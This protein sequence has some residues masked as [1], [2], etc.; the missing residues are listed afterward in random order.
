MKHERIRILHMLPVLGV[1]GAECMAVELAT[2]LSAG[3]FASAVVSLFDGIGSR[4][5][6]VLAAHDIPF[7][8]LGKRPGFDPGLLKRVVH[9]VEVFAPHVVHTHL[10]TLSYATPALLS[11]RGIAAV[12]TMHRTTDR[13]GGRITQWLHGHM[14]RRRVVPVAV[15]QAI[16]DS[17]IRNYRLSDVRVIPNGIPVDSYRA[18][19]FSRDTW[20]TREGFTLHEVL[21]TC[22]AR[23]RPVKNHSLLLRA[24]AASA[25]LRDRAKL[26][27]VGAGELEADLRREAGE[28]EI[29]SLVRFMGE[30]TDVAD[31]LHASDAFVLSSDSEA[32]SLAVME[33]MA[34]GLPVVCTRVGGNPELVVD[35]VHGLMVAKGD[36]A[37]LTEALEKIVADADARVEMGKCGS[38]RARECFDSSMMVYEYT[39]LYQ[40]LVQTHVSVEMVA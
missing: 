27:I 35:G 28:L 30:R 14:L 39:R 1:G 12:H 10:G 5:E 25:F 16:A 3:L 17:M 6:G 31:L 15:A 26:L 21:L 18:P 38:A 36:A 24:F 2:N 33:A 37:G 22:V 32:N 23:M 7:W 40:S 4:L 34:A 9:L 11:N 20:R 8:S 13:D 29:A 19:E